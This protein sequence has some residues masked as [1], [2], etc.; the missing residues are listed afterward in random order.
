[1]RR[2]QVLQTRAYGR[3]RQ[4]GTLGDQETAPGLRLLLCL[5]PNKTTCS[6]LRL[7]FRPVRTHFDLVP[8]LASA[9]RS[10][11]N[12]VVVVMSFHR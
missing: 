1:M 7:D 9:R 5:K 2:S 12:P 6:L 11:L 3:D 8:R 4:L 10:N